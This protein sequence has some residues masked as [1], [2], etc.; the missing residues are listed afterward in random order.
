MK[1]YPPA[2]TVLLKIIIDK[3]ISILQILL[4][5]IVSFKKYSQKHSIISIK[6][7]FLIFFRDLLLLVF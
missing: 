7:Y 6:K 2:K 3:F 5:I 1:K 4:L